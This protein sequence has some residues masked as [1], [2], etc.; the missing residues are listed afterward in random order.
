ML[1]EINSAV[2]DLG[3]VIPLELFA[4]VSSFLEEIIAPIP[5]PLIGALLGSLALAGGYES[6]A[7]LLWLGFLSALGKTLAC[8]LIYFAVSRASKAAV[9]R[10]GASFGVKHEDLIALS[11][12]FT[13]SFRDYLVLIFLRAVPFIP[14]LPISL[15]AGLIKTPFRFYAIATLIGSFIRAMLFIGVGYVGLSAYFE[16]VK[17][18]ASIESIV[19]LVFVVLVIGLLAGLYFSNSK[20]RTS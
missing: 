5:S 15:A 10:F 8:A 2:I 17:D 4:V 11:S 9:E 13:G 19:L 6:I 16:A 7:F 18:I 3:S 20:Q 1:E 14:S 12:Y